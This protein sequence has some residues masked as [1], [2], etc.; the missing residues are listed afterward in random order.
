[1]IIFRHFVELPATNLNMINCYWT[2]DEALAELE[3]DCDE[4]QLNS[5]REITIKIGLCIV[6]FRVKLCPVE[7]WAKT[8]TPYSSHM[9]ND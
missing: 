7:V 9:L 1:M 8:P 4:L 2:T 3:S 6:W 5:A